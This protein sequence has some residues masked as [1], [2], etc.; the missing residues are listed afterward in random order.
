[1]T[2]LKETKS[3]FKELTA[4]TISAYVANNAAN[5][6]RVLVQQIHQSLAYLGSGGSSIEP[7]SKK[8]KPIESIKTSVTPDYVITL[9][10]ARMSNSQACYQR[11]V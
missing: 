8:Q 2:K 7:E 11:G 10:H 3:D 6:L 4:D 1:M 5:G 9:L